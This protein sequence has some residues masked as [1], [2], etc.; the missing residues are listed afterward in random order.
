MSRRY[1][2][3]ASYMLAR[4]KAQDR[5][6]LRRATQAAE[7]AAKKN[8]M[9][10][11]IG[12]AAGVVAG[13]ALA[14]FT[15]GSSLLAAS[16]MAGA[17]SY[18]GSKIGDVSVSGEDTLDYK[19]RF[20]KQESRDIQGQLS[21]ADKAEELNRAFS[22]AS[23]A[24]SIFTLGGGGEAFKAGAK[25]AEG[26]GILGKLKAGTKAVGEVKTSPGQLFQA[27]LEQFGL[28]KG[29]EKVAKDIVP[30]SGV[31]GYMGSEIEDGFSTMMQKRLQD[32]LKNTL[33][34]LA[35]DEPDSLFYPKLES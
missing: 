12:R 16:A 6:D 32:Q 14:P 15:A 10:S 11:T 7:N 33:A 31:Q 2:A 34:D 23:D 30:G 9:A 18:I 5:A 13:V 27:G 3:R 21:E 25:G 20:Y 26:A 4:D 19:G 1:G 17:G 24:F 22:A 35:P 29:K 28:K 8:K